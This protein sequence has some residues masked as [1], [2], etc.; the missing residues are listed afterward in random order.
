MSSYGNLGDTAFTRNGFDKTLSIRLGM[1]RLS[2]LLDVTIP[3]ARWF[4]R[5][6]GLPQHNM[7]TEWT[8]LP[9]NETRMARSKSRVII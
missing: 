2:R 7:L 8:Y 6:V 1:G 5:L 4:R 3:T 9:G